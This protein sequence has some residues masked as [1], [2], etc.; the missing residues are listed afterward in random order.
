[1]KV[2]ELLWQTAEEAIENEESRH[3]EV[4]ILCKSTT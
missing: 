3:V 1:M 2:S 4:A